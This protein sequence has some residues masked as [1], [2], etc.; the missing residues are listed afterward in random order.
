M[1]SFKSLITTAVISAATL[2][3]A[4]DS[5]SPVQGYTNKGSKFAANWNI[6][7]SGED[8][9]VQIQG[10]TS[11]GWAGTGIGSGMKGALIFIIYQ[12][13][14]GNVTVSPRLG[15]GEFEPKYESTIQFELLGGSGIQNGLMT[16]N[17]KCSNCRSWDG[18]SLDVSSTSQNF[19][20]ALGNQKVTSNSP[21]QSLNQH[22]QNGFYG[23]DLTQATG[24]GSQ[25]PFA[26]LNSTSSTSG[27]GSTG[28]SSSSNSIGSPMT[29]AD[30]VLIAHG[31]ILSLTSY[32]IYSWLL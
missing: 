32:A 3:Y 1:V 10:P 28:S 23:L 30:K 7:A 26:S 4:Q 15:K 11:A 5:S 22:V 16:G 27:S 21:S 2:T 8:V 25:N 20:W 29:K 19:I 18:G 14:S 13:G 6:P 24:G 31:M 9:Y 12:D 17:I